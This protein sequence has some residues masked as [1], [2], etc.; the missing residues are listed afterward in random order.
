MSQL[1]LLPWSPG[2][3]HRGARG[4]RSVASLRPLRG[5]TG[6]TGAAIALSAGFR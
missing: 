6:K 3:R 5:R 1:R 4:A 2:D